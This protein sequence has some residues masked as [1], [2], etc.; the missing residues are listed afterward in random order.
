MLQQPGAGAAQRC[1]ATVGVQAS[2]LDIDVQ[3]TA[4]K[5]A[6]GDSA[7]ATDSGTHWETSAAAGAAPNTSSQ[8]AEQAI[9][10]R[11]K[12]K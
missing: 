4:S 6:A 12:A 7:T 8:E 5:S 9:A 3:C 11:A 10:A 1:S 2:P